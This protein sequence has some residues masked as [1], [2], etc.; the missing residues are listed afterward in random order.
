MYLKRRTLVKVFV[1]IE[2][3]WQSFLLIQ[4]HIG[5]GKKREE[6]RLICVKGRGAVGL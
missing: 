1:Y 2:Y 4:V 5:I 3:Y 6:T